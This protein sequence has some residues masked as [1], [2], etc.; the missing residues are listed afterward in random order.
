M[1][2]LGDAKVV[3][4]SHHLSSPLLERVSSH[5]TA[6]EMEGVIILLPTP[7]KI[8]ASLS[9]LHLPKKSKGP[10]QDRVC[11]DS[12][13][14]A[15]P[16]RPSKK[17]KLKKKSS[18]V[19][20]SSLELGHTEG[21]NEADLTD[22]YAEIK[23]SL[24]KD[25]S[26]S[27]RVGSTPIPRLG[28][29][30]GAPPSMAVVSASKLSMLGLWSMLL[31]LGVV[32]L[33]E[34]LRHQVDPLDFLARS[35]LAHDVEYDQI[36]KDDFGTST[37][38]EEI[39][40][41]LFPLTPV[42]YQMSYPYKGASS[43]YI[44]EKSGMTITPAELKRTKS[45]LPLDLENLFNVLS[46]L[47]VSHGAE[48][49]SCYTGPENMKL[50][51]Q[52]DD[53]FDKVKELQTELT[54][55]RVTSI[56][57]SEELSQT[58]AKLSDQALVVKNLQ[59]QLKLLSSDEFHAALAR[60]A[61]LGINYGVERGLRMRPLVDFP[62]IPFPFLSKIAA[63]FRG[64]LFEVTQVLPDKHIRSVLPASVVLPIVNKDADQVILKHPHDALATS[65]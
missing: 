24:E 39:D 45:L 21:M 60:V 10:A 46:A 31:L 36:L 64:T 26:T 23:D 4:E 42:P 9:D 1:T 35:A 13:A 47:L 27:T 7:A 44:L 49:N 48:L 12:D 56:G 53:A 17:R 40:L 33:L 22:F 6:L 19:D 30:L 62:T 32:F 14:V 41:T 37:H 55:A 52:K 8:P 16:S 51:S 18:G 11:L 28:K 65:I 50:H 15:E 3:E 34:V 61:S 38:G 29:R 5:T 2:I 58:D 54:Y 59:N 57:L 25:E 63:A 43:P 20:S